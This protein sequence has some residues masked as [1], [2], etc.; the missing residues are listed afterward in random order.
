MFEADS[1]MIQALKDKAR[2]I[3][4]PAGLKEKVMRTFELANPKGN[5]LA[6]VMVDS[7]DSRDQLDQILQQL[8]PGTGKAIFIAENNPERA[9]SNQTCYEAEA[10][11]AGL[12][13]LLKE[14]EPLRI[15]LPRQA[16]LQDI[17]VMY[18]FDALEP[19]EV[20]EL[21]QE[22][23]RTGSGFAMRDLRKSPRLVGAQLLYA[24]D[25][26]GESDHSDVSG[27]SDYL[28]LLDCS[29][30]SNRPADSDGSLFELHILTTTKSRIHVPDIL[31]HTVERTVIGSLEAVYL[32][33]STQHQLLWVEEQSDRPLQYEIRT[34]AHTKEWVFRTAEELMADKPS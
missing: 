18:G 12:H 14:F 23:A 21:Y 26:S 28:A 7:L 17:R 27:G 32:S 24:S 13:E 22:V 20:E 2:S 1:E 19:W 30:H 29:A 5:M 6:K 33:D 25:A 15:K 11:P 31:T 16:R 4:P 3:H 8:K 10:W 9:I 34:S